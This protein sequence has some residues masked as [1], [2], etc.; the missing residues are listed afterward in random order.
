MENNSNTL[1]FKRQ[2]QRYFNPIGSMGADDIEKVALYYINNVIDKYG[3]KAEV[4]ALAITGSR[5][6][7]SERP[8]SDLDIVVE[9]STKEREDSLF[10]IFSSTSFT[11]NG[12]KVDINPIKAD[13][14]GTLE[15]YLERKIMDNQETEL[16]EC[17]F[18]RGRGRLSI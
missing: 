10:N 18:K 9:F 11:I 3:L 8:N 16:K 5:S 15:E 12:I 1:I 14:N 17:I 7:G 6:R 13:K 2:T 4:I